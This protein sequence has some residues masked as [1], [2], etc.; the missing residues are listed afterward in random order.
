[1]SQSC[2]DGAPSPSS[3]SPQRLLDN[4]LGVH[5]WGYRDP[6]EG[7]FI[8]DD[9]PFRMAELLASGAWCVIDSGVTV[10]LTARHLDATMDEG[11]HV[12]TFDVTI[13]RDGEPFTDGRAPRE[14]LTALLHSIAPEADDGVRELPPELW[15][16]EAIARAVSVL[17]NV[18]EVHVNRPG[19]KVR[20]R[21]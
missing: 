16:N 17:A 4:V 19:F 8:A 1:M 9:A 18:V 21:R 15:S 11:W 6:V 13:W 2:G 3:P 14:A 5:E 20:L 10:Q 12:H 7:G